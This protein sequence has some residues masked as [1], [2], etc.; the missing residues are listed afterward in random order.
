MECGVGAR[1]PGR[2]GRWSSEAPTSF[3]VPKN[4]PEPAAYGETLVSRSGKDGEGGGQRGEHVLLR[5]PTNTQTPSRGP[6][7][8]H[9]RGGGNLARAEP[10]AFARNEWSTSPRVEC[11]VRSVGAGTQAWRGRGAHLHRLSAALAN[12]GQLG[13]A[14]QCAV[15]A[16]RAV[17][18]P[19]CIAAGAH[20]RGTAA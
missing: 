7:S 19:A 8:L 14:T 12:S 18:G 13:E 16:V 15:P 2:A 1:A 6:S 17:L 10:I 20:E 5:C 3:M 4:V 11:A 9:V